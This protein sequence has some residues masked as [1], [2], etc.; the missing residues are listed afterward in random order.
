MDTECFRFPWIGDFALPSFDRFAFSRS[1]FVKKS[2]KKLLQ[3]QYDRILGPTLDNTP[4][5]Y[6]KCID[7]ARPLPVLS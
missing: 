5:I 6:S 4:A 7:K 1:W 2:L 3:C